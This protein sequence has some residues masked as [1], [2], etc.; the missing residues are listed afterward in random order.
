MASE[1]RADDAGL[2]RVTRP[3]L[4]SAGPLVYLESSSGGIVVLPATGSVP[5]AASEAPHHPPEPHLRR[6][7]GTI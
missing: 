4:P 1:P 5:G 6:A 3:A 2:A 7:P